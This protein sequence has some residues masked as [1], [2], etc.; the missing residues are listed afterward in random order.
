VPRFSFSRGGPNA[1]SGYELADEPGDDR[2]SG[3]SSSFWVIRGGDLPD[4][5]GCVLSKKLSRIAGMLSG[6]VA[7]SIVTVHE[8]QSRSGN[9]LCF[10]ASF[11][12]GSVVSPFVFSY[13]NELRDCGFDVV[14]CVSSDEVKSPCLRGLLERCYKVIHRRNI[15]YDFAS[16]AS[17]FQ[18]IDNL[19][20]WESLLITNDSILGPLAPLQNIFSCMDA[21]PAVVWGLNES[22]ERAYHLQSFFLYFPCEVLQSRVFHRFWRK[23][24]IIEEK[25]ELIKRY[26]IGLSEQLAA[27][28]FE[29]KAV[30][31]RTEVVA[32]CRGLG[33]KFQYGEMLDNKKLNIP[34]YCWFE[35]IQYFSYP[36]VKSDIVK[37]NRYNSEHYANLAEILMKAR[38]PVT[39][40]SVD[41]FLQFYNK[42]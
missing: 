19:P 39:V 24:T 18:V 10:F 3:R 25:F 29:L 42:D 28:G 38:E 6:P 16:W 17:C 40:E 41:A 11:D 23:V 2:E 20:T 27:A 1:Q 36:F 32:V 5:G 22:F 31:S 15:G 9:K 26:E 21:E 4:W 33:A 14:F 34:L 7:K 35:L 8:G 37:N 12:A 13:L 30:F